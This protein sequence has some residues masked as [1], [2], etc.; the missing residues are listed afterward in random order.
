MPRPHYY[1]TDTG[2]I[3]YVSDVLPQLECRVYDAIR[4]FDDV[5]IAPAEAVQFIPE[6]QGYYSFT[7]NDI[8]TCWQ[9]LLK[10]AVRVSNKG[11]H[12]MD[13][14]MTQSPFRDGKAWRTNS[15]GRRLFMEQRQ[16][17]RKR[18]LAN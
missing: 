10:E 3:H 1:H 13:C 18:W 7:E 2:Y 5:R 11:V 6:V 12:F 14:I 17:R 8:R 4:S 16:Q 15:D 9:E